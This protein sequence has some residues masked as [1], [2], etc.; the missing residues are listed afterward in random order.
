MLKF[1][2]SKKVENPVST[3][4]Q[5]WISPKILVVTIFSDVNSKKDES[6]LLDWRFENYFAATKMSPNIFLYLLQFMNISQKK[7]EYSEF[8]L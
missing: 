2:P 7:S 3:V 5:L 4:L 6:F 8:I 1:Q